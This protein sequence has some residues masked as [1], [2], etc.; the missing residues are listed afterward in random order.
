M[1]EFPLSARLIMALSVSLVL[2][3]RMILDSSCMFCACGSLLFSCN[4]LMHSAANF[5]YTSRSDG[6][7][8]VMAA[9]ASRASVWSQFLG[10][11]CMSYLGPFCRTVISGSE[12]GMFIMLTTLG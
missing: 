3:S 11:L 4:V 12:K 1:S 5:L 2:M 7:R 9:S 6:G 10:L 8:C